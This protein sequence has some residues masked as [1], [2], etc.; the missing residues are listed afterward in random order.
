MLLSRGSNLRFKIGPSQ[1]FQS[2]LRSR[3]GPPPIR[4]YRFGLRIR[5]VVLAW[6]QFT[7]ENW[8]RQIAAYR[9]G[10]QIQYATIVG[11]HFTIQNWTRKT[12]PYLFGARIRYAA[13]A[14]VH[15]TIQNWTQTVGAV[16]FTIE[17]W[18]RPRR[19]DFRITSGRLI[20]PPLPNPSY[21]YK[22]TKRTGV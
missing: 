16:Q 8:T 1:S 21:I 7:F 12:R 15:F 10:L 18:T 17:N 3:I 19:N 5:N 2:I 11:V 14:G 6:V 13:I 4:P 22:M 9:F 20:K